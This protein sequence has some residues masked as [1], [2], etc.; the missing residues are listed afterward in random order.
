[1]NKLSPTQLNRL[2]QQIQKNKPHQALHAEL[3]DHIASLIEQRMDQGQAFSDAFDQVL[4]QANPQ[5]LDQ[6]KQ[7]YLQEFSSR[8]SPALPRASQTKRRYK[9]RPE[10]KPFQYMLLSSVL[11]FLI[12]MGF[13]VVVSRP[14]AVPIDA[15]QTAWG[16][17]GLM[18]I[19]VV[20]WWLVRR[21]RNPKRPQMV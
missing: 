7:L 10:T 14:L 18:G 4:Q 2:E 9:R 20:Q 5:A 17:A 21:F 15:F 1:M 19:L 12:L 16:A 8:P 3:V 13:L 6:L 11:T